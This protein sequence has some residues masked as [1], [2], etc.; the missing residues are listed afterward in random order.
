MKSLRVVSTALITVTLLAFAI[1]SSEKARP[2]AGS[3]GRDTALVLDTTS[4]AKKP[5]TAANAVRKISEK[6]FQRYLK[7]VKEGETPDKRSSYALALTNLHDL[8]AVE[9]LCEAVQSDSVAMV[10][11]DIMMNLGSLGDRRAVPVL[12]RALNEDPNIGNRFTAASVLAR[13]FNERTTVLPTLL[14][15]FMKKDFEKQD[16]ESVLDRP[17]MRESLRSRLVAEYPHRLSAS[18][19]KLLEE[20]GGKEV[21]DGLERALASNDAEVR[22]SARAALTRIRE[23]KD[24]D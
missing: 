7:A 17:D 10:R 5:A 12:M 21:V 1:V 11:S 6:K 13:D 16:W 2:S 24:A 20:I 19:L 3:D 18:A 9:T 15:L 14:D 22:D 8:R 4:A 23:R